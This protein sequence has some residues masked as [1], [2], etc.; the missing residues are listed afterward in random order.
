MIQAAFAGSTVKAFN[1]SSLYKATLAVLA[2]LPPHK[3]RLPPLTKA[4]VEDRFGDIA[5]SARLVAEA[6]KVAEE[7]GDDIRAS[8]TA[9][10]AIHAALG[11]NKKRK[12][13]AER[14]WEEHG[15]RCKKEER[16]WRLREKERSE[17][18]EAAAIRATEAHF[19]R[20]LGAPL[21]DQ[22]P[23]P[24]SGDDSPDDGAYC[25]L[26]GRYLW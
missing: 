9:L 24:G 20:N 25:F 13:R 22:E 17:E 16:L 3:K 23:C 1:R 15:K 26:T 18:R 21:A 10:A 6:K 11:T 4:Q 8:R 2:A 12:A 5:R 7:H 14:D 19:W